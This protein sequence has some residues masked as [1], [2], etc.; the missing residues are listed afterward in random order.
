M[1]RINAL[2]K[3]HLDRLRQA[4]ARKLQDRFLA[5]DFI[6][7]GRR[8]RLTLGSF[9]YAYT[10]ISY[11][12][13]L[14]LRRADYQKIMKMTI[15]EVIGFL[16][17][18]PY[19]KE[20][21]QLA[22]KFR[23]VKLME[24]AIN[25]NL[26]NSWLKLKRVSKGDLRIVI[27]AYLL[28]IDIWNIKTILRAKYTNFDR[29][30]LHAMLLPAGFLDSESLSAIEKEKT[31]EDILKSLGFIEYRYF[32][33]AIASYR[34]SHSLVEI[35]TALDKFFYS[36]MYSFSRRL[37][38]AGKRFREFLTDELEITA[39]M[40]ILR[41]KR[42][43]TPQKEI[44]HFIMLPDSRED[45]HF[46]GRMIKAPTALEAA[47]LLEK[48]RFKTV[49]ER[50]V[51][52]FAATGSLT[53]LELD[54]SADMLKRSVSILHKFPVTIDGVMGYIFA[55]ELEARNLKLILKAKQLDMGEDF[56]TEQIVTV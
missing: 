49:A 43:N 37:P 25:M 55:K 33:E 10:R 31:V 26:A 8:G 29:E 30:Q 54:L 24:L 35:E 14:L 3:E 27:T 21:D 22:V 34:K 53:R 39:I 2:V 28:R 6:T 5:T 51:K 4:V 19:R 18:S 40:N 45:A 44:A 36:T 41:L 56:V 1:E 16:E 23:G 46:F 11:M 38:T 42:A 12:R 48:R 15:N 52:E 47:R 50:G 32:A 17:N 13:S 7:P 9:P 20:I